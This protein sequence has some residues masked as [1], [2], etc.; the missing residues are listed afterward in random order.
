MS[1]ITQSLILSSLAA[2]TI[3]TM[4]SQ[5][6]ITIWAGL[7]L[8]TLAILPIISKN[9][10]PRATEA[11]TK[12]F[13]TQAAA[14]A[15]ILMASTLNAW[16]TG[17]WDI[18]Q[19]TTSPAPTLLTM[20]LAMKLGLAPTHFWLPEVLQGTT[21]MTALLITTW[22]KLAPMAVLMMAHN[23]LQPSLLLMLGL[24]SALWG[25]W[26]GLNQTQLRKI[27]AYSSIAHLGWIIAAASM[28]PPITLLMLWV[29]ILLTTAMFTSMAT[30]YLKTV[31]DLSTAWT[32]SPGLV[33]LLLLTL[34]S[35]AGLPPLTGFLPKWLILQELTTHRL[36]AIAAL[37]AAF[38]LLSLYFYLRLSY[39]SAITLHPTPTPTKNKWRQSRHKYTK[40]ISPLTP[41]NT[42]AIPL[43]PTML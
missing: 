15:M 6:W 34:L 30:L 26:A 16:H 25:G 32:L 21:L 38:S 22:Q 19:L 17:Q 37:F 18:T 8:N 2:G 24:A 10:H 27:M 33:A 39:T 28:S 7:E 31:K 36:T 4:S 5:S 3:I 9:H 20:A 14:S 13:L 29:Y 35:L 1:P 40:L 42:A 11:T 41:I 23:N 43:I 12:Y